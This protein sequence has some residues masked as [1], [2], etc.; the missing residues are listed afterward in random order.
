MDQRRNHKGNA[1]W[2][3]QTKIR[4][5]IKICVIYKAL[6]LIKKKSLIIIILATTL[7]NK[8]ERKLNTKEAER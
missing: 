3:R 5:P 2:I 6:A 1:N 8:R 7:R 4:Q